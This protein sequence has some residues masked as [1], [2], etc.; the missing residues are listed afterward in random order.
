MMDQRKL[1]VALTNVAFPDRDLSP[2][3]IS[4]K[5]YANT[6]EVI[7][8][9]IEFYIKQF[10]ITDDRALIVEKLLEIQ[11]D[12]YGF[13]LYVW[14]YHQTLE[15]AR[16]IR[17]R[18]PKVK[19][20]MGGPEASGLPHL[21]LKR[22][23][24]ID[25]VVMG[26]G[27]E[28]FRNLLRHWLGELPSMSFPGIAYES[29]YGSYI[30]SSDRT[31]IEDVDMLES[32][33]RDADYIRYL[34]QAEKPVTVTFETSR[35][36]PFSCRYCS[37]GEKKNLR[38]FDL[39]RV[40][41]DLQFLLQARGVGRIYI[42]DSDIFLKKGRGK[43]LLK[44]LLKYN[45]RRLP[46]IFEVNPERLDEESIALIT[47]FHDDEFAF[48]LQSSSPRVLE[49]INRRF[50]PLKYATNIQKMKEINPDIKIWF[51]CIIGLPGDTLETFRES[52]AFAVALKP[53]SLYIHEF[54]CLPGSDFYKE[55]ER[56]G[57]K[58]QEEA[59][60]KLLK[61]ASFKG[62]DYGAAKEL[63]FWTSLLHYYPEIRE[64][65]YEY[66]FRH[67]LSPLD[68]LQLYDDFSKKL[69]TQLHLTD[70]RPVSNI[71]SFEFESFY[72]KITSNRLL[73]QEI[74]QCYETF[75]NDLVPRQLIAV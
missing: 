16:L 49:A 59:P 53:H 39:N 35:G 73:N 33:Y 61:H 54:L 36:C 31:I 23:P 9:N 56:F 60:H 55:Q 3:L 12:I 58:C 25:I 6:D 70:G 26:E 74:S 62:R 42:T 65:F 32:P 40:K 66:S 8:E 10:I 71:S 41:E 52:L 2:A 18:D 28:P 44:F 69:Q 11:A 24:F 21:L 27:E 15:I 37:W 72:K 43:D 64:G 7:A 5:N 47:Q 38:F 68:H 57:I 50:N 45:T 29:P 48:G 34:D 51:S 46:V 13:S 1:K 30:C 67:R 19:I 22:Y 14:N 75:M 20:I 63:G 4:L 17:L